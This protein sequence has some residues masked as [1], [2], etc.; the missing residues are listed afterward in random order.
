M[1]R[2]INLW[3]NPDSITFRHDYLTVVTFM[4]HKVLWHKWAVTPLMAVQSDIVAAGVRYKFTDVQTYNNRNIAGSSVKSNHAWAL[5]VDINPAKNPFGT[6]LITDIPLAVRD[7]FKRHGFKWG[8]DYKSKKDA[9]HFE[10]LG[11]TVKDSRP[12]LSLTHPYT[13]GSDVRA[14]Q[15]ALNRNGEWLTVD[16][17]FGP[18]T[19]E[20]VKAFQ[21]V[22]HLPA[23]GVCGSQTWAA[24]LSK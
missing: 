18:A 17:V 24:L 22:H 7:I 5:A 4:G 15:A 14:L 11:E 21:R 9:M 10:Y 13:T 20:A 16:G 12:T 6:K 19:Q 23:D 3:G 1:A 2:P 8:G